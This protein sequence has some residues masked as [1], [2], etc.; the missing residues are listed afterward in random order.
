M[1]RTSPAFT[2]CSIVIPSLHLHTSGKTRGSRLSIRGEC[3]VVVAHDDV[4]EYGYDNGRAT[5]DRVM[6]VAAFVMVQ[7]SVT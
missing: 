4:C 1:A 7:V 5:P 3:R 2:P 6:I